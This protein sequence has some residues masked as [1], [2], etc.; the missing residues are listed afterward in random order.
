MGGHQNEFTVFNAMGDLVGSGADHKIAN[1][2]KNICA[3]VAV[4]K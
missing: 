1:A 3:V 2:A 4:K